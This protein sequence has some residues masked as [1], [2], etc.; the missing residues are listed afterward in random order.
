MPTTGASA[1]SPNRW[2]AAARLT[3][4]ALAGSIPLR[5]T[6]MRPRMLGERISTRYSSIAS[7]AAMILEAF[8]AASRA[9]TTGSRKSRT[10]HTRGIWEKVLRDARKAGRLL[11][12]MMSGLTARMIWQT[13]LGARI[14]LAAVEKRLHPCFAARTGDTGKTVI[15]LV[16]KRSNNGPLGTAAT[17]STP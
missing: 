6:R 8:F 9:M 2:R 12:W 1:G 15:P 14:N 11:A 4:A 5:T 13:V 16:D 10:C 17:T 7:E 3:E